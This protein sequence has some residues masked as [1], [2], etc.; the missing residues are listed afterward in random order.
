M[1]HDESQ[2]ISDDILKQAE[3]YIEELRKNKKLPQHVQAQLEI[4]SYF[5]TFLVHDHERMNRIYP[6]YEKQKKRQDSFNTWMDKFQW[7][8]IPIL[9]AGVLA[10]IG[11]FIYFWIFIVP[12]LMELK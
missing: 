2:G 12:K 3:K 1:T 4:Q 11:Q 6:F 10:F 9:S 5:L 7:V 8:V